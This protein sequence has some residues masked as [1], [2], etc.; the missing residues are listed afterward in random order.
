MFCR[1]SK[2]EHFIFLL[3]SMTC[4]AP[5]AKSILQQVGARRGDLSSPFP[6]VSPTPQRTCHAPTTY[7]ARLA[8]ALDCFALDNMCCL[9]ERTSGQH[10]VEDDNTLNSMLNDSTTSPFH[11]PSLQDSKSKVDVHIMCS[12]RLHLS[13]AHTWRWLHWLPI[14]QQ[15]KNMR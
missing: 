4:C 7:R 5:L 10:L 3:P 8:V 9:Y 11:E 13:D 12:T 1:M 2:Q 14:W 6:L 15:T